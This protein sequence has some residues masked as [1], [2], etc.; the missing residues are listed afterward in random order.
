MACLAGSA[1][2]GKVSGLVTVMAG[3]VVSW[4]ECSATY[5]GRWE[6]LVVADVGV[7]EWPRLIQGYSLGL[8]CIAFLQPLVH[9]KW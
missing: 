1:Y 7:V 3:L 6:R 2:P 4:T 5:E 9:G 8:I